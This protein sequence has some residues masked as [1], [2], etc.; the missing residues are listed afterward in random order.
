MQDAIILMYQVEAVFTFIN[1]DR[2][3]NGRPPLIDLATTVDKD[4]NAGDWLSKLIYVL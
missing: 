3:S 4:I 2:F 1:V